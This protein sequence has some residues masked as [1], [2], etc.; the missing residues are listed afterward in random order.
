[1]GLAFINIDL[2]MVSQEEPVRFLA[3][4]GEE[5]FILENQ[6]GGHEFENQRGGTAH[7]YGAYQFEPLPD[8]WMTRLE[9]PAWATKHH[10][11]PEQQVMDSFRRLFGKLS[12]EGWAEWQAA[13]HRIFDFGYEAPHKADTIEVPLRPETVAQIAEW[14]GTIMVT[15]YRWKKPK[16]KNA[17]KRRSR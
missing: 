12:P 5:P 9:A 1:M 10:E 6:R 4:L 16:A 15:I 11:M 13:P 3:D 7:G 14:G 2:V 17:K 8:G